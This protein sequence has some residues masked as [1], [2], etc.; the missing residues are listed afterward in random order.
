M[1]PPPQ[2]S[3]TAPQTAPRPL[4]PAALGDTAAHC[5]RV[6]YPCCTTRAQSLSSGTMGQGNG[7][8]PE[9]GGSSSCSGGARSVPFFSWT[10][11]FPHGKFR[12]PRSAA[13]GAGAVPAAPLHCPTP[14][15]STGCADAFAPS[16]L[17]QKGGRSRRAGAAAERGAQGLERPVQE[18]NVC[19][20]LKP[21]GCAGPTAPVLRRHGS[22][23]GFGCLGGVVGL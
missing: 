20:V 3:Q 19:T 1:P 21:E 23:R 6:S 4:P 16:W 14:V 8:R 2:H 7:T 18:H 13:L 5:R 15:S 9:R 17:R 12:P 22:C 10:T 11:L